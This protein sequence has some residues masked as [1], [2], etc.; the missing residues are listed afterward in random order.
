MPSIILPSRWRRQ[1]PYPVEIASNNVYG[2]FC[3]G[4]FLPGGVSFY[5]ARGGRA[6]VIPVT[7]MGSPVRSVGRA[8][9]QVG[10]P[11][12]SDYVALPN[13]A[14]LLVKSTRPHTIQFVGAVPD[15]HISLFSLNIGT[16]YALN[17]FAT[18][19]SGHATFALSD[20]GSFARINFGPEGAPDPRIGIY[21]IGFDGTNYKD[22]TYVPI[23]CGS[24]TILEAAGGIAGQV[25]NANRF[26][27]PSYGFFGGGFRAALFSFFDGAYLVDTDLAVNPW[28]IFTPR[29]RVLYFETAGGGPTTVTLGQPTE[30][31]IAQAITSVPGTLTVPLGQTAETDSAQ[32]VTAISGATIVTLGQTLETDSAQ[33]IIFVPGAISVALGQAAETDFAQTITPTIGA[34]VVNIGLVTEIDTAQAIAFVPGAISVAVG[35]AAET[36]L[37]QVITAFSPGET[38]L[39]AADLARARSTGGQQ[40]TSARSN[41]QTN[42]RQP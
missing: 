27:D 12:V 13:T 18:S 42:R 1:P 22:A 21:T 34:T 14:G 5:S 35:Q 31:D 19:Y 36:D 9:L 3:S 4:A 38:T 40:Q 8:G 17:L 23:D 33:S 6:G 2:R 16:S 11:T 39:T 28:Q 29:R 24:K 26:F 32:A 25:T 10:C 41:T 30:T 15:E 20:A 7:S 37:A